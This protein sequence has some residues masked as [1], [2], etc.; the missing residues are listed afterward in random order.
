MKK[1][2]N[3]I[4][5]FLIISLIIIIIYLLNRFNI[6][7][8]KINENFDLKEYNEIM[9]NNNKKKLY[10]IGLN[11]DIKIYHDD[12]YDKCNK[13][14]CIKF[15]NRKQLLEKCLKCN[16]QKNKCFNKSIIGGN[17]DDCQVEDIKDKEDCLAINNY[18][19]P[20]PNNINYLE[21]NSGVEPYYL[22]VPDNNPNTPF[23]KKCVFCW[24]ILDNI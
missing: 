15:E 22:E 12:C 10:K 21:I 16:L 3:Y 18:G 20:N 24:N 19:C 1:I 14:E 6:S 9:L 5:Y 11:N 13:E 8:T 7:N 17:C 4:Y 23:N 2:K